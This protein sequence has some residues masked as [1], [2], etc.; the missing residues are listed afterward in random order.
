[1]GSI[2]SNASRALA[3]PIVAVWSVRILGS[4]RDTT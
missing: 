3:T 2:T 4:R 1:M